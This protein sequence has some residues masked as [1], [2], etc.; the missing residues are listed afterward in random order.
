MGCD[1][2]VDVLCGFGAV[3]DGT[4][5]DT[6]AIQ[7]AIDAAGNGGVVV[8]PA[9]KTFLI[10][11]TLKAPYS[12]HT[13]LMWGA[14]LSMQSDGIAVQMGS[15]TLNPAVTN[16]SVYGGSIIGKEAS[17]PGGWDAGNIGWQWLNVS[18][19]YHV[20]Y[21][22]Y[23]FNIGQQL[24]GGGPNLGPVTITSG[25]AT[26]FNKTAHGLA[27]NDVVYFSTS[28]GGSLPSGLTAHTRYYVISSGLSTNQFQV[29]ATL[30][31]TSV[32]STGSG[33]GTQNV[34]LQ[35]PASMANPTG[36][37]F[38][39][40]YGHLAPRH[41]LGNEIGVSCFADNGGW[42]N[43]NAFFGAGRIGNSSSDP[44]ARTSTPFDYKIIL[45]NGS[46]RP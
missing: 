7:A 11:S 14:T 29:S 8:F 9:D 31:G 45:S 41:I 35:G 32:S 24:L 5:D 27:A 33:S 21:Y 20:D 4:T 16:M 2:R 36:I 22:I 12:N 40:Q 3:G 23:G 13:W 19:F 34:S 1:N 30:G 44:N 42:C 38:G 43:E 37:S 25:M 10:S 39:V 46:N 17:S 26:V 28:A 6:A 15:Y 18:N